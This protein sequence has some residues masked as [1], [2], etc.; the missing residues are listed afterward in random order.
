MEPVMRANLV[1]GIVH[2]LLRSLDDAVLSRLAEGPVKASIYDAGERIPRFGVPRATRQNKPT[3]K[4]RHAITSTVYISLSETYDQIAG[5][6]GA[7]IGIV[8]LAKAIQQ[9]NNYARRY[10]MIGDAYGSKG[11]DM[12][13]ETI[14]WI[15]NIGQ[16]RKMPTNGAVAIELAA[17]KTIPEYKPHALATRTLRQYVAK[18][19][20]LRR[21]SRRK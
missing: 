12:P 2:L 7:G 9:S 6:V 21:I 5:I 3:N 8:G 4:P 13:N 17:Q 20:K 14:D 19:D 1:A 16:S 10:E 15:F 11:V 18:G